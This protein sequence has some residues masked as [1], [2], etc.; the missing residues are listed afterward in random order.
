MKTYNLRFLKNDPVCLLFEI[1]SSNQN[2]KQNNS[3]F[4]ENLELFK[5]SASRGI[6]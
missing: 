6:D 1:L 2:E 3:F 5:T 4:P